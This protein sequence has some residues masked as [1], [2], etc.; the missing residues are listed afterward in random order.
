MEN[1]KK[2]KCNINSVKTKKNVNYFCILLV[3]IRLLQISVFTTAKAC[4]KNL[5]QNDIKDYFLII[6]LVAEN[7]K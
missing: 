4:F 7:L 2:T 1:I 3:E 5:L 6:P